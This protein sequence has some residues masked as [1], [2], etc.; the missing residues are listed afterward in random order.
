VILGLPDL[1]PAVDKRVR[2]LALPTALE[3]LRIGLGALGNK[4]G[5]IGAAAYAGNMIG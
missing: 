3:N 4:A 1:V 5:V 2:E